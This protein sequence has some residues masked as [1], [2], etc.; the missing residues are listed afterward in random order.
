VRTWR[1]YL[2]DLQV[3]L[4]LWNKKIQSV[5]G[6]E[7]INYY[8]HI[9]TYH[10]VDLLRDGTLCKVSNQGLENRHS[11]D[12]EIERRATSHGGG[13]DRINPMKQILQRKYRMLLLRIYSE[14]QKRNKV[15]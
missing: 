14:E 2:N 15:V 9:V 3:C 5:F 8:M 4:Y 6:A 10:L 7:S 12:K 1:S 13:E 11:R